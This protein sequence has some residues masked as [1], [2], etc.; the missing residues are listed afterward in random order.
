M[1]G[2]Y[3]SSLPI[4][5]LED[6][7]VS[8]EHLCIAGWD[9]PNLNVVKLL[10]DDTGH[11]MIDIAKQTL[12]AVKVSANATPNAEANPIY[13]YNVAAVSGDE[14]ID[15]Q[16][17]EDLA[18]DA[19]ASLFLAVTTSKTLLLRKVKVSASGAVRADVQVGPSATLVTK[20]V[21]YSS[22]ANLNLDFDYPF[23]IEIVEATG[24]ERVNVI[25]EN[26]DRQQMDVSVTFIGKEV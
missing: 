2:D 9:T 14:I 21:Q 3:D 12:T 10:V 5:T 1:P 13:V 19:S 4:V 8:S 17:E 26:R 24:G 16:I 22:S 20:E 6:P 11:P 15:Y 25:L 23:P 7:G 18:K